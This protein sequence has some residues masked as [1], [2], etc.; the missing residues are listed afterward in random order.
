M[1]PSDGWGDHFSSKQ[2]PSSIALMDHNGRGQGK[3][4]G[5]CFY[6]K[7]SDSQWA[8]ATSDILW[9]NTLLK[10]QAKHAWYTGA[11]YTGASESPCKGQ[12]PGLSFKAVAEHNGSLNW[13]GIHESLTRACCFI[14][15]VVIHKWSYARCHRPIQCQHKWVATSLA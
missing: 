14:G 4:G 15:S 1:F 2:L 8:W 12:L 7:A 9:G 3:L 5:L 11:S 6:L 10:W 13:N